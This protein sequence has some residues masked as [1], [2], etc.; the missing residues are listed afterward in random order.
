MVEIENSRKKQSD[1]NAYLTSNKTD[2][3]CELERKGR[4]LKSVVQY[5]SFRKTFKSHV[6]YGCGT[7]AL[8]KEDGKLGGEFWVLQDA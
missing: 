3:D 4:Y 5:L 7:C 2:E 8:Y 1:L 6:R